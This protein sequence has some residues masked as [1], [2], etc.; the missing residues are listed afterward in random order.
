MEESGF[1]KDFELVDCREEDG[2]LELN[3]EDLI[4]GGDLVDEV[5]S[6]LRR[7]DELLR[8]EDELLVI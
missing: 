4:D 8:C 3:D 7:L 2:V 6:E 5:D 1:V